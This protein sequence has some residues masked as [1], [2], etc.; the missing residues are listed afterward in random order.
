MLPELQFLT[1]DEREFLRTT[2]VRQLELLRRHDPTERP[3]RR[4]SFAGG[5]P[6]GHNDWHG[7]T[8]KWRQWGHSHGVKD[9]LTIINSIFEGEVP[10]TNGDA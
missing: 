9:A 6:G 1:V 8:E 2:L 3:P 4:P 7:F 5:F 10:S